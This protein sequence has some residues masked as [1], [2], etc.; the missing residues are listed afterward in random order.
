[1]KSHTLFNIG[2]ALFAPLSRDLMMAVSLNDTSHVSDL[3]HYR[4][5]AR[6]YPDCV[7]E[8][9]RLSDITRGLRK[10]PVTKV[11]RI[12]KFLGRGTFGEVQLQVQDG[13]PESNEL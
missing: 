9:H 11:W 3:D 6:V 10:V 1:M 4:L 8:V 2:L 12:E 13:D 7:V 5:D